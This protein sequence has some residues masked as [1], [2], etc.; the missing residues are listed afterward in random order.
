MGDLSRAHTIRHC[1]QGMASPR[2]HRAAERSDRGRSRFGDRY[3]ARLA[4]FAVGIIGL[5]FAISVATGIVLEFQFGMSWS[6]HAPSHGSSIVWRRSN[7]TP[8]NVVKT[9]DTSTDVGYY[10]IRLPIG[11][12][13]SGT[14]ACTSTAHSKPS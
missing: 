2:R 6:A 13:A 3:I 7:M 9:F 14:T 12:S 4:R 10:A 5:I 8:L 11:R 1:P